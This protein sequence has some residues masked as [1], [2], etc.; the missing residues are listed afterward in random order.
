MVL[1]FERVDHLVAI[2]ATR[3][4][5]YI[6]DNLKIA[7][8]DLQLKFSDYVKSQVHLNV[9]SDLYDRPLG[10][11]VKALR[12]LNGA[13]KY[14]SSAIKVLNY[15]YLDMAYFLVNNLDDINLF[16]EVDC[17]LDI[18]VKVYSV[19]QV[20]DEILKMVDTV[21]S[22][23]GDDLLDAMHSFEFSE[24]FDK[25]SGSEDIKKKL[26]SYAVA[27]ILLKESADPNNVC[28]LVLE[29]GA[30]AS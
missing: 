6:R 23:D 28:K 16:L 30:Y 9:S 25:C 12:Y 10:D 24:I 14:A 5:T 8:K 22:D 2:S 11:Y 3:K 18:P 4:S 26:N 15:F 7:V 21:Q 27:A 17:E 29:G 1:G 13:K 20:K 19:S